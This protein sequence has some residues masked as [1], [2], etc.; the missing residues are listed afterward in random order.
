[1]LHRRVAIAALSILLVAFGSSV[2]RAQVASTPVNL[3]SLP[4]W[5]FAVTPYAWLPT[6][7]TKFSS[8]GPR[9]ATVSTDISAGIGDYLSELN[10]ALMVGGEARYDRFSIMTDLVY[11]NASIT[12]SHS[13]FGSVNL[14]PGPIFIPR[15][16]QLDTGTRLAATI[17]SAAGGYT[18]L[19]G[20]WGNLDVVAGLRMLFI[21]STTS[22]TLAADFFLRDGTLALSRNGSLNLG[23]TKP[24]GVG[25]I[26]GRINIPNSSFYL[27]FYVDAGGGAVP[28]TW[29]IYGGVAYQAASWVD[30]SVGYR[31][32]SFQGGSSHNGFQN[33]NLNG[34]LLAGNFRF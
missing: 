12:T 30:V 17:W 3:Q 32:L 18:V 5:S 26:T 6:I 21:D 1:M 13:H 28:F 24:E 22:Y 27:P 11:T 4:G 8:T 29:Q 2:A 33:L 23:T 9:G 31:Y 34:V 16:Q 25:G 15:K 19:R 10:F 20:E 14:G 7:S